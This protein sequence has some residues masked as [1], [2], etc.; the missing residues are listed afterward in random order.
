[1]SADDSSSDEYETKFHSSL[2]EKLYLSE[3]FADFHFIFKC[4]SDDSQ[5]ERV[6]V[7]KIILATLNDVFRVMFNGSWKEKVEVE[8]VDASVDAF[9]EFLQFF[10]LQKAKVTSENVTEV[11]NLGKKYGITEC[12][13]VCGQ[14]IAEHLTI[15]DFSEVH[16]LAVY[17]EHKKLEK[18]CEEYIERNIKAIFMSE[19][20]LK[21][22]HNAV[23]V[24][25][26]VNSLQCSE[27]KV[28][29]S[30]IK[31]MKAKIEPEALTKEIIQGQFSDLLHE[32]RFGS[33]NI[34]EFVLFDSTYGSLFTSDELREIIKMIESEQFQPKIFKANR[35]NNSESFEW[36]EEAIIYCNRVESHYASIP[37][38]IKNIETTTFTVNKPMALGRFSLPKICWG[39]YYQTKP[40][41]EITIFEILVS[42]DPNRKVV[43]FNEKQSFGQYYYTHIILP[44]PIFVRPGY[45]Y[46]IQI[47]IENLPS[48]KTWYTQ[49]GLETEVYIEPDIT[50]HFYN[51]PIMNDA[52]RG[53]IHH[54]RFNKIYDMH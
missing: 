43:L 14:F 45:K 7:H 50:V 42:S 47:R 37:Y 41:S 26:Q 34:H 24:I 35:R 10:Y 22:N 53:L 21:F 54:L 30:L 44:K 52:A 31:W 15:D 9:K 16:E 2:G 27:G 29:D 12:F 38:Y 33:M 46:E 25:L 48:T 20:F 40:L 4:K 3:D 13:N 39:D 11:M 18:K 19:S 32:I 36:N 6:P 8:I 23:K 28:F 49:E 5:S 1:M 17:L 51:D